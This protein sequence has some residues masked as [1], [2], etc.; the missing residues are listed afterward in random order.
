MPPAPWSLSYS[1]VL[2]IIEAF[3]KTLLSKTIIKNMYSEV[4][5]I[6]ALQGPHALSYLND[7]GGGGQQ[8]FIFIPKKSQLQNLSTQNNPYVFRI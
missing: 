7:K 2:N 1:P 4:N 6:K 3:L 5:V 8:R